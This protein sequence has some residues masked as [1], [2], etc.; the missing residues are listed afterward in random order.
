VSFL[1]KSVHTYSYPSSIFHGLGDMN[2]GVETLHKWV[3]VRDVVKKL[4][5]CQLITCI[6]EW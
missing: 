5:Y 6:L 3:I 4:M 1:S 2:E